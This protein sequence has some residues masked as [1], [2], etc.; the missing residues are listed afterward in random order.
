MTPALAIFLALLLAQ[1]PTETKRD[2]R[3]DPKSDTPTSIAIPHSYALVIGISHYAKLPPEGQL[4]F[5]QRDAEAMYTTLISAEGGQFP[6]ENVHKLIGPQATLVNIRREL[7]T[8][9]PSVSKDDDRVLIYFA[10][11]GFVSGAKA[12]LAPYDIDRNDIPGTSY[13]MESLG[14]T[15]GAKIKGKWKVLLTDACHS[16]A[17]TPE[18]DRAQVN[19]SLLDLNQS[20]FSLTASRDREQSFESARWGGGHGIFTYYV[21][22]GLEGEADDYRRWRCNLPTS[23][24]NTS[25][26]NVREPPSRGQQNPTSDTRQLRSQHG[27]WP[28]IPD[29]PKPA[30]TPHPKL[31]RSSSKPTWMAWK[32]SSMAN[33]KASSNKGDALPPARPRRRAHTIKAVNMGYEPDGPREEMC[34]SGPGTDSHDQ[35][36]DPAAAQQSGRATPSIKASSYYNEG[37]RTEL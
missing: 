17:I 36:S 4:E 5:P 35:D 12:Y 34:L 25:I 7:E 18:A 8:W 19:R 10:G 21:W 33:P 14:S 27:A 32:C 3:F 9:L 23:L 29:A 30:C 22:Q 24:P 26:S 37:V 13:P 20:L 6:P 16:G 1:Q 2:L 15:F 28:I 31:A 11:H